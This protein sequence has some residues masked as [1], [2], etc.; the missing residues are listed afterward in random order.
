[1]PVKGIYTLL[2]IYVEMYGDSYE[3]N[4]EVYGN[5]NLEKLIC[6]ENKIN[7][8]KKFSLQGMRIHACE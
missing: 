4:F 3:D 2:K 6:D 8:R 1:M 7:E 5:E